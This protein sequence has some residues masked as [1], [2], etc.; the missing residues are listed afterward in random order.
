MRR[1]CNMI[2]IPRAVGVLASRGFVLS[3]GM[4]A[5]LMSASP[6]IVAIDAY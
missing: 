6:V 1:C 4:G 3:L 2:A 5:L